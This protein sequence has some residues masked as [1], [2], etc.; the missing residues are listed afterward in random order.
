MEEMSQIDSLYDLI[1]PSVDKNNIPDWLVHVKEEIDR[2]KIL[3]MLTE[4]YPNIDLAFEGPSMTTILKPGDQIDVQVTCTRPITKY[5]HVV[6]VAQGE[7][8]YIEPH[9]TN[10][11][12][13]IQ[14]KEEGWW[15]VIGHVQSRSLLS[16]KRLPYMG[17]IKGDTDILSLSTLLQFNMPEN[18]TGIVNLKLYLM[19]DT[20]RGCDQEYELSFNIAPEQ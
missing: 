11:S 4:A 19:S 10:R 3:D 17:W 15:L 1:D 2:G 20:W 13:I 5:C 16:I 18:L 9:L 14:K 12:S 6:N 8:W 7:R